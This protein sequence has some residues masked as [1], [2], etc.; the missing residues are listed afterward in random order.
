MYTLP[1]G[2]PGQPGPPVN[3]QQVFTLTDEVLSTLKETTEDVEAK[4]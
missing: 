1:P 4:S 2:F 3:A